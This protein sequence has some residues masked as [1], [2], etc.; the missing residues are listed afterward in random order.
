MTEPGRQ[1]RRQQAGP[2]TPELV[3]LMHDHIIPAALSLLPARM[4]SE[5]AEAMLLAIALQESEMAARV[6]G[7]G[8]PAH[9]FWQFESGGGVQGV[10]THPLTRPH[11][12]HAC[13]VL[14]YRPPTRAAV[15]DAIVDND[16]LACCVARLLLWT[17]PETLATRL[18][19]G[20]GWRQ[21][22]SLWRPGKPGPARWPA[23]FAEG[24]RVAH[25]HTEVA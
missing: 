14:C 15:Y 8:G 1:A 11:L 9:G 16:V 4:S 7:G 13:D 12:L 3:V 24:W 25:P 23:A 10:L 22:L 21:Y 18:E 5:G 6:Q 2:G 17:S 20:K 19:P